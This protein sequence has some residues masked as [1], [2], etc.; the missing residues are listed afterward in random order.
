MF[1][2][3]GAVSCEPDPV[4]SED[5]D[6]TIGPPFILRAAAIASGADTSVALYASFLSIACA[7]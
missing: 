6:N 3:S 2:H 4:L 5:S 1:Q 7:R